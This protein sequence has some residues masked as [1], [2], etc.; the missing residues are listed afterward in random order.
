MKSSTRY[1]Y[2]DHWCYAILLRHHEHCRVCRKEADLEKCGVARD[3]FFR[4]CWWSPEQ[5]ERHRDR[6]VPPG[7]LAALRRKKKKG[8]GEESPALGGKSP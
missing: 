1:L 6:P 5:I 7:M 3:L 2:E 8:R 4:A